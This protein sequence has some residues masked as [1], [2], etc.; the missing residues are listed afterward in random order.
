MAYI[1][2]RAIR[3]ISQQLAEK[4]FMI[5]KLDR[6]IKG[7]EQSEKKDNFMPLKKGKSKKVISSNISELINSGRKKEQ[8]VAIA[9]SKVG[10]S[11]KKKRYGMSN[12]KR[13]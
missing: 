7:K 13:K 1:I 9:M 12:L 10:M 3:T 4:G 5:V 8:A 6:E 2:S 11:K